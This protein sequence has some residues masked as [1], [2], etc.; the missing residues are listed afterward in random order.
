MITLTSN[1]HEALAS[2]YAAIREMQ[3][4]GSIHDAA[5]RSAAEA[6]LDE[7]KTRLHERGMATDGSDIGRSK[8]GEKVKLT[9]TGGLKNELAVIGS[10]GKYGLGWLD[11][12]KRERAEHLEKIYNKR[13]WSLTK[14]EEL[15]AKRIAEK[16][17]ND[18]IH[19]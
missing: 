16:I 12:G 14:E 6:S 7:V 1:I 11:T 13:I 15:S 19:Q 5:M 3:A 2:L 10:A 17:L 18:A 4:G 9:K 8:T